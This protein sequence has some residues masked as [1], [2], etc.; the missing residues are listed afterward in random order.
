MTRCL[1]IFF[2]WNQQLKL[3]KLLVSFEQTSFLIYILTY[4]K[5]SNF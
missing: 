3:G 1:I 2:H 5:K 4:K